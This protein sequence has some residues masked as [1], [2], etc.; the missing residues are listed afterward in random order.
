LPRQQAAPT[1]IAAQHQ[2]P[3]RHAHGGGTVR[4]DNL[5]I[6]GDQ[7]RRGQGRGPT[8]GPRIILDDSLYP[9]G[10]AGPHER[11]QRL[12]L[13][14]THPD[15]GCHASAPDAQQD[16]HGDPPTG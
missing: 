5:K 1:G 7:V 10:I 4:L 16:G 11:N 9:Y 15:A 13:A 8:R 6:D 14:G 3:Y 2:G 12:G